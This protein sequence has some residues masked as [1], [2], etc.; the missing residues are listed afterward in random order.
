MARQSD[1]LRAAV[2][3]LPDGARAELAA[4]LLMSLEPDPE[5][6]L[7]DVRSQWAA[8]IEG[9][10]RRLLDGDTTSQAWT[11]VRQRLADALGE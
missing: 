3:A 9:R 7:D 5:L 8:E 4:E 10:A 11:D 2:L 1:D 6:D